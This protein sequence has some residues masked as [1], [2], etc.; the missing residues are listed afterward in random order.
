LSTTT[1]DEVTTTINANITTTETISSDHA[2]NLTIIHLAHY[3]A[4]DPS[5][6]VELTEGTA[7]EITIKTASTVRTIKITAIKFHVGI[8]VFIIEEVKIERFLFKVEVVVLIIVFRDVVVL[9]VVER[10]GDG[11]SPKTL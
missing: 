3:I 8:E 4:I 11:N 7:L 6:V 9:V 10:V 1:S 5:V 2:I